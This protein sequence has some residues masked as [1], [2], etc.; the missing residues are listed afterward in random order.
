VGK[1]AAFIERLKTKI[2]L[3][4]GGFAYP[5]PE[6]LPLDPAGGSTPRRRY[7]LALPRSPWDRAPRYC[8][9]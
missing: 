1:F 8:G 5:W 4:S 9:L 3:A 7:R 6:A 2:A